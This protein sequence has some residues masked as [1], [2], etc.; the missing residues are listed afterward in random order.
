MADIFAARDPMEDLHKEA[1]CS[2]CQDYFKDPVI[3]DCGHN[4][5]R[6]C[7]TQTWE[8][9]GNSE[10]S[11]PQCR[12]I[13]SQKNLRTNQQLANVAKITK[14]LSLEGPKKAEGKEKVCEKHKEPLKLFCKD[15]EILFCKMC[16]KEHTDHRRIPLVTAAEDYKDLMDL[17]QRCLVKEGEKVLEYKAKT[18][19]EA[20]DLLMQT[21]TKMETTLEEIVEMRQFLDKQE[22]HLR[23]Q[24]E[25]L[26]KQ[27][28]RKRDEHLILLSR[29]LS[30][31]ESLIQEMKEK[32]QQPP[33]E[34]LQDVKNLLQR[35]EERQTSEKP[36]AFPPELK[37]KIREFCDLNSSLVGVMKPFRDS[38]IPGL[39]LQKANVTLDPDT[40]NPWLI[41][42]EDRKSVRQELKPQ[43]LPDN[44]E[45]FSPRAYVLGHEGFTRGRHF[46]EVVV[47]AAGGW[48]V[49]VAKKSVRRKG[50]VYIGPEEG[51]WAVGKWRGRYRAPSLAPSP[52]FLLSEKTKRVRVFLNY[53]ANQV[54]FYDADTGDQICV[55]ADVP[56]SGETVIPFF[57][58]QKDGYLGISP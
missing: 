58:V 57:Y 10:T 33:A 20:Q 44:P 15:D 42:S 41:L 25:E 9:S 8:K 12:E 5:C 16:D 14:K 40:G 4:F 49:G 47:G 29:E 7:L 13:V 51:I 19:K 24:L 11:C 2:V 23:A 52:H 56:F 39:E 43:D 21:K 26:K 30:S 18:E 37:W 45:R 17:H 38:L 28:A 31:L 22:Q 1:T 48:A 35:C 53:A 46:W 34:L 27:V 55:F 32:C 50:P 36:V 6:A 3:L 54:A